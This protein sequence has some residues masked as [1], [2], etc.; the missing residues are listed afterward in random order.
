MSDQSEAEGLTTAINEQRT[1]AVVLS[2]RVILQCVHDTSEPE[3]NKW[4]LDMF[5]TL[6]TFNDVQN[7]HDL[8]TKCV[9]KRT[10][11]LVKLQYM[12]NGN[13]YRE[14]RQYSGIQAN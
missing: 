12:A 6:Q 4:K 2:K 8:V 9:E 10:L 1:N 3:F 5:S 14:R 7:S 13:L 11:T